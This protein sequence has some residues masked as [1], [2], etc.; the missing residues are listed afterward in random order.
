MPSFA[1]WNALPTFVPSGVSASAGVSSVGSIWFSN[2]SP[3]TDLSSSILLGSSVLGSNWPWPLDGSAV[4]NF[5]TIVLII[6]PFSGL[7]P[8]FNIGLASSRSYSGDAEDWS[9]LSAPPSC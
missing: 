2:V 9:G 4:I 5:P 6:G 7:C 8:P 1:S 3:S